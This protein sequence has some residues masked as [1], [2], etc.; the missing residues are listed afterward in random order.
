MYLSGSL[1]MKSEERNT[2]NIMCE[3][4]GIRR[5]E[6]DFSLMIFTKVIVEGWWEEKT[7]KGIARK[8]LSVLLSDGEGRGMGCGGEPGRRVCAL[9]QGLVY[10][11][12]GTG[13]VVYRPTCKLR[14]AVPTP[15]ASVTNTSTTT[16]RQPLSQ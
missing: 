5:S 2:R 12:G 6:T 13:K 3:N 10:K 16:T 15:P 11:R 9:G 1:D 4:K 14:V 7:D 8:F